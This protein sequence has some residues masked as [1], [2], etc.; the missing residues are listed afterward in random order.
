MKKTIA[1]FS[2]LLLVCAAYAQVDES[3]IGAANCPQEIA[4]VTAPFPMPEFK[5]PVFPQRSVYLNKLGARQKV[6]CTKTLQR[7]IDRLSAQGG[8][9]VVIPKGEWLTGRIFL[10]SNINLHLEEGAVLSFSEYVKDYQP[11]V[12]T[13]YEGMEMMGLGAMIYVSDAENVAITGKGTII[14]PRRD[15]SEIWK[16]EWHGQPPLEFQIN[17]DTPMSER[18]FDGKPEHHEGGILLPVVFQPIR[19][20]GVFVEGV[21]FKNSIFWNIAPMYCE[22]VI[23]RGVTID[24][25]GSRT[26]GVDVMSSHN[27]LIEYCTVG[28]GD[29]NFV[30]KAGRGTD[31]VRVG[32][33][34][35]NVVVR[36]C[37]SQRGPGGLTCGT[38]TSSVIR[39][40]Y[41]HDCVMESPQYAFY[42]KTRRPRGGGVENIYAERVV[43]K[44]VKNAIYLDELGMTNL[45]GDL[46]KRDPQPIGPLTP[47]YRNISIKDVTVGDAITLIRIKSLPEL[48]LT[49]FKIDNMQA[50]CQASISMYDVADLTISNSHITTQDPTISLYNCGA[51]NFVNTTITVLPDEVV[52]PK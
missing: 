1:L 15:S 50:N 16:R 12:L 22:N 41:C 43:V 42:F 13:R 44:K 23:V 51:I 11:A 14:S 28:S 9:N 25:Y 24:S 6:M 7:A 35:E 17:A 34:T 33:P 45:Y 26:D 49:G 5:R 38:E 19:C 21:T 30:M 39:N 48:P 46:A 18:Y 29:D 20:K 31:G 8:G 4:P 52:A 10:R 47:F 36:Y 32:I 37:I 40:I 2:A 27:V 3:A